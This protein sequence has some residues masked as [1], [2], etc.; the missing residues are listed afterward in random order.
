MRALTF[1]CLTL[2]GIMACTSQ[3]AGESEGPDVT[4]E[5]P[6]GAQ[7]AASGAPSSPQMPD[8][9]TDAPAPGQGDA[10]TPEAGTAGGR[11]DA[12]VQPLP[13]AGGPTMVPK[14]AVFAEDFEDESLSEP[15]LGRDFTEIVDCGAQGKCVRVAYEPDPRGSPRITRNISL[16]PGTEYTLTYRLLFEEGFQ[17]VKGGKLPGLGPKEPTTGCTDSVP[18]GWSSRLMWRREGRA[19]IYLYHQEREERCGDD[20]E[21]DGQFAVGTWHDVALH[22]RVNTPGERDG[23][24][25]LFLNGASVSRREGVLFR[26]GAGEATEIGSLMFHTFFGGSDSSWS[27]TQTVFA[28]YDDFTVAKGGPR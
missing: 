12:D 18:D 2:A 5:E 17:F 24:A 15:W 19:V 21:G 1:V 23:F 25:E 3:G 13:E 8:A 10:S 4:D 27:P 20:V 26:G 14:D 7:D 22:V 16:P 28:R 11:A 9:A 6:V